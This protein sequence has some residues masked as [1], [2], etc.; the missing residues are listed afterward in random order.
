MTTKT[1][2]WN[3][4]ATKTTDCNN[5]KKPV[6]WNNA[7]KIDQNKATTKTMDWNMATIATY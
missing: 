5:T 1:T 2:D 6:D 3:I 7:T 4:A